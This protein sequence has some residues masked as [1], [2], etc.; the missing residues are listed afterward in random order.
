MKV[1]L[2]MPVLNEAD[3]MRVILPKIRREWIHQILVADGGSTDDSV[4]VA[5]DFGCEVFVQKEAGIRKAYNEAW[6]KITGDIVI[7]FSPDGNCTPEDIPA[8]IEEVKQGHDMVIASRY[9]G[10]IKSLDDDPVTAFGNWMFTSLINFLYGSHYLD[11]M[12]IYR[13]YRRELFHELGLDKDEPY[14]SERWVGTVAGIEPLLSI[15]A[16]KR[17]LKIA[18][19]PSPEPARIGGVRK[20]QILR[21]GTVYLLQVLGEKFW[22]CR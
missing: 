15:R 9:Y 2:F 22:G 13:A 12:G 7:T 1:T 11:A 5:R 8:L 14:W 17:K 4:K 20:L 16:A 18:E 21:W 6:P 10:G 19:I 3:G